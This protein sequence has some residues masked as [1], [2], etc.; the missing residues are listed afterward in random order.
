MSSSVVPCRY[1]RLHFAHAPGQKGTTFSLPAHRLEP[2]TFGYL[3]FRTWPSFQ[4]PGTQLRST[5]GGGRRASWRRD[6]SVQVF[7]DGL[8]I[9]DAMRRAEII[10]EAP[11]DRFPGTTSPRVNIAL[12]RT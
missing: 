2:I 6:D 10:M 3:V 1:R 9:P 4:A 7:V 5:G 12:A 11:R 8:T